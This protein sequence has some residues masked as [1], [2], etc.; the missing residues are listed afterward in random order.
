[1]LI[2]DGGSIVNSCMNS[3]I[4]LNWFP[5]RL[6]RVNKNKTKAMITPE[7]DKSTNMAAVGKFW[8]TVCCGGMVKNLFM[9]AMKLC[10]L[11]LSV[12]I[13]G[14][15]V[16]AVYVMHGGGHVMF[17]MGV[18]VDFDSTRMSMNITS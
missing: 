11:A 4:L 7:M 13:T 9:A 8:A 2:S 15:L 16:C 18:K 6:R 10:L 3:G 1:V 17:C 14:T 12:N 5:L